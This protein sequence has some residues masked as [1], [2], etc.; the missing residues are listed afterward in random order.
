MVRTVRFEKY[1]APSVLSMQEVHETAPGSRE[2]W[3]DQEA[4]GVNYLDVQQRKGAV[5][6]PL[7]SGLG[8]EGAGRVA[9]VGDE[10]EGIAVGDRVGYALGPVGGYA[11]GRIYPYERLI[12][13]PDSISYEH[14]AAVLF[15]GLTAQYLIKST[16]AVSSGSVVL[17]YGA[18]GAVG[19]LI[20]SWSTQ[21]G[22]QVIGVVSRTESVARALEAGCADVLIWGRADIAAE[23]HRLT[24][25]RMADVV[26]DGVGRA[27]FQ[28]SIDSLKVRGTM[29]SFGASSGVP[30]PVSVDLLNKKSLFLTRPGL[31]AYIGNIDEY[32]ARSADVL[33][34][35]EHE[36][37]KPNLWR[38]FALTQVAEVHDLL[39]RGRTE[40]AVI[41]KP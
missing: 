34:A 11:D 29:V 28:S 25:G 24:G 39:E 19:Q 40:G 23:V 37:I 20:A 14:A 1:G 12:R 4:I 10:V 15:K 16:Y 26:Y 27:T 7:P 31:A 9:A 3:L 17:V 30:A 18:A 21:L 36:L 35:L 2:V 33:D 5:P 41:L 13:L 38:T 22:G 8:L 6:V 32:R